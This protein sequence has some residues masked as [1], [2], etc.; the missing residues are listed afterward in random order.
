[1]L[2]TRVCAP[3][4]R[5]ESRE[6]VRRGDVGLLLPEVQEVSPHLTSRPQAGKRSF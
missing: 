4:P 2:E 1:V 5:G 3:T 6:E